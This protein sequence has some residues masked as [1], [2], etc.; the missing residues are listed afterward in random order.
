MPLSPRFRP[1][2]VHAMPA[3]G[4]APGLLARVAYNAAAPG[5]FCEGWDRFSDGHGYLVLASDLYLPELLT[6]ALVTIA[7]AVVAFRPRGRKTLGAHLLAFL[8]LFVA[9]LATALLATALHVAAVRAF[10]M[11][12][13]WVPSFSGCGGGYL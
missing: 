1:L 8:G 10:P 13:P 6:G 12:H 9:Y 11:C 2:L 5:P 4:I 3:A 7:F